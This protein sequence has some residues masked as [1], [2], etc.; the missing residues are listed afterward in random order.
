MHLGIISLNKIV[1]WK[2][3]SLNPEAPTSS[4]VREQLTVF[5]MVD[6]IKETL[7]SKGNLALLAHF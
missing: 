5:H 3:K 7:L 1:D 6:K 2:T 4:F